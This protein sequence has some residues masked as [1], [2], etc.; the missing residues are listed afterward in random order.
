MEPAVQNKANLGGRMTM[1]SRLWERSYVQFLIYAKQSQ[2]PRR[3]AGGHS[4]LYP[5]ARLPRETKPICRA[6]GGG[7]RREPRRHRAKQSQFAGAVLTITEW[8]LHSG[9]GFGKILGL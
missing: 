4:P 8:V 2:L 9:R 3:V 7:G 6:G 5:M 1:R